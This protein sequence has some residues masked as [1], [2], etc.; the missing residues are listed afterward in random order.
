MTSKA[1]FVYGKVIDCETRCIH[2]HSKTDRIAIKFYCCQ[3]FFPCYAC[4]EISGCGH[5]LVWPINKF[6]E[7]AIL[8]GACKSE[9][10][11]STYLT[12]NSKCPHCSASFNP[13]CNLHRHYYFQTN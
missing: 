9:L 3:K 2:Y 5:P 1:P 12:C 8:C 13:G 10:S 4:H 11:I 6:N 7:K